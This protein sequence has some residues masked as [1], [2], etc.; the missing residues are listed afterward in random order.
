MAG[1]SPA[2]LFLILVVA[3]I[4]IGPGKLPEVGAAIGKSLREFQKASGGMTDSLL[5]STMAPPAE[6]QPVAVQPVAVQPVA[7]QPV[8]Q[9][10]A[11]SYYA[12]SYYAQPGAVQPPYAGQP[13]PP[14]SYA[15]QASEPQ[16]PYAG[17]PHEAAGYPA[18][19]AY[20]PTQPSAQTPAPGAGELPT[21]GP[22][23]D[24]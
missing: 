12:Q 5:K 20:P 9:P 24:Q 19:P 18:V 3:L 8:A 14:Q 10:P 7:V 13:Y 15:P 22:R 2:H 6:P 17:Q 4:V 23:L 16:Q 11:Q 21:S 1:L